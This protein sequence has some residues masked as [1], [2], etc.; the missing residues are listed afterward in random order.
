MLSL[1][2]LL[3]RLKGVTQGAG[4]QYMAACPAHEDKRA[5]LAVKQGEKGIVLKCLAGC[6]TE[7]VVR[8]LGLEM[9]DLFAEAGNMLKGGGEGRAAARAKSGPGPR[10]EAAGAAAKEK[11]AGAAAKEKDAGA[12]AK[13]KDAGP[14]KKKTPAQPFLVG[15]HYTARV[16]NEQTGELE[17]RREEIVRVYRYED[18]QGQPLI[19]VAR[20][21]EK[22]F[23]VI[24]REGEAW[25][26]G[27]GGQN[28]ILYR[29]PQLIKGVKAGRRVWLVE[30]EKDAERLEALG[31]VASC[32]KGGAGKW[33]EQSKQYFK[34]AKVVIVPDLDE[35][36][37]KHARL[38]AKGL[39]GVAGE[40]RMLSLRKLS[41]ALPAHGDVSDLADL[42]GDERARGVL[43][44][45]VKRSPVLSR[46]V[47]DRDYADYFEGIRG[48]SVQNGCICR[49]KQDGWS[50]L[51]N[52][53]ALP[54]EEIIQDD[55][56]GETSTSFRMIGW[57][58]DGKR[59]PEIT[60]SAESFAAMGWPLKK[61]G[62]AANVKSGNGVRE[63]LREA[64][65]T[66]GDQA[67]MRKVSYRHTGWRY[68]EGKP[69]YLHGGGGIGCDEAVVELD[70]GFNRYDLRGVVRGPAAEMEGAERFEYCALMLMRLMSLAS[71]RIGLPLLSYMFLSPLRHFLMMEGHR[72]S[73]I[74]FL[75]GRT[76]SGKSVMASLVLN[77]FGRDF[78]YDTAHPASF[79]DTINGISLKL[80]TLKDMP[81]LIDDYHPEEN[82]QR[83]RAMEDVAQRVSRMIGDGAKRSRMR[84]DTTGQEDK[85][86][87]GLC[88]QTG[89][90]LPR[91]T[92]SGVARMY[93]I[94]LNKGDVPLGDPALL[95][96]QRAAREGCFSEVMRG[97]IEW[98][99]EMYDSL[100]AML[101]ER[102]T[103]L[104]RE[105]TERVEGA[106]AR[107]PPVAAYLVLGMEMMLRFLSS[108]GQFKE[109][110]IP[111]MIEV[112]WTAI[113]NN[114]Q[115]QVLEMA[116]EKPT[117]IFCDTLRELLDTEKVTVADISRTEG[118][119]M[120]MIGYRDRNYFYLNPGQ[121]YGAVQRAMNE[122]GTSFPLGKNM[123]LKLLADEG[124]ILKDPYTGKNVRQLNKKGVRAWAM[125][126]P[127]S[128]LH[129]E[130]LRQEVIELGGEGDE[131]F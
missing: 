1:Q 56:T 23:P 34:G 70:Y 112:S 7:N 16:K 68:I 77:C 73:F 92:E 121:T 51:C 59:L 74:P 50:P 102:Y 71:L 21:K 10:K 45:A 105:A 129:T 101:D 48:Y 103:A 31:F 26:W 18:D 122:Q 32:N 8:A 12:A 107:I 98:L 117:K 30:G 111:G 15:G 95:E 38:I 75:R 27:D 11:D 44:E 55:G 43:E 19:E 13:A 87:R 6:E 2:D 82:P 14:S 128:V 20:T 104:L 25:Y 86:A 63:Q 96:L 114:T 46:I 40:V 99:L 62:L 85:P 22:S 88:I 17:S 37:R 65:Q 125:W 33:A 66:A 76:G 28:A 123:I 116:E 41:R 127:R 80:F 78:S 72:P 35:P 69:V 57:A 36:G 130:E 47:D 39:E 81:L 124:L 118:K 110:D 106:H 9:A 64:I 108:R 54:V 94:D 24:H 119:P 89:E 90:E 126:M 53:T 91:V 93:V 120:N 60:L 3:A 113:L 4:G 79:D 49:W 67:A 115:K 100:P 58:A 131:R 83:R 109:A 84:N 97:Y 61:W 52:F 5:S 29:L 42:L